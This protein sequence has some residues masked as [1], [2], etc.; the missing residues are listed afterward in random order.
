MVNSN[1]KK[2]PSTSIIITKARRDE[3]S[4]CKHGKDTYDSV[5]GRLIVYYRKATGTTIVE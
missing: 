3:L 5:I 2:E 4:D 1:S